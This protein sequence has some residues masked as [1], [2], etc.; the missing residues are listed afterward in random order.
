[1]NNI[2]RIERKIGYEENYN[3]IACPGVL[4]SGQGVGQGPAIQIRGVSSFQGGTYPRVYLD[5]I[6]IDS[7]GPAAS[8]TGQGNVL[9]V[10]ES[11]PAGNVVRIRVLSGPAA[12]TQFPFGANGVILVE[13][14]RGQG[15]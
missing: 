3:C 12:T 10:L 11:I 15:Q 14:R 5:G 7:D 2:D 1:M 13:T 9:N 8:P 4:P 6:L